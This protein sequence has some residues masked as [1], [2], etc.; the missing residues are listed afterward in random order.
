MKFR[1]AASLLAVVALAGC[2][3]AGVAP[4][5]NAGIDRA[6]SVHLSNDLYEFDYS[7][8]QQADA[9][10][11]LRR[12]LEADLAKSRDG[13]ASA[14]MEGMQYAKA[15]DYPFHPYGLWVKWS[16][17]ADL[18]GWLSLSAQVSDYSGGAH[19]NHGFDA[20]VWD[21]RVGVRRQAMDLFTS[22]KALD[23][24]VRADLCAAL[25]KERA[26]KRQ[27]TPV[28]LAEFDECIDPADTT[29]TPGSDNGKTFDRIGFLIAPYVAGPYVEGDYEVTLPVTDRILALV[30]PQY[31]ASFGAARS[32][33]GKP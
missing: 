4:A 5:G 3:P 23:A 7:W 30:K 10:P 11:A 20:M 6:E 21:K 28:A 31:R 29:I 25:D 26:K 14:S 19:P 24:A 15:D 27:G 2:H 12:I 32:F 1:N 8:P 22:A 13:L 16:V 9:I 33:T 18:P 17:V